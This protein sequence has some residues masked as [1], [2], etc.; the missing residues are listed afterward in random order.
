MTSAPHC[1]CTQLRPPPKQPPQRGGSRRTTSRRTRPARAPRTPPCPPPP[2]G[3]ATPPALARRVPWAAPS[4]STGHRRSLRP[5]KSWTDL[6]CASAA[7]TP[8]QAPVRRG[9]EWQRREDKVERDGRMRCSRKSSKHT[10]AQLRPIV[11]GQTVFSFR[12]EINLR[13]TTSAVNTVNLHS[14]SSHSFCCNQHI[15]IISGMRE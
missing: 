11:A 12:C 6:A 10:N 8:L 15:A 2:R 4:R 13:D 1:R 5:Q 14:H 7:R 9:K 3:G